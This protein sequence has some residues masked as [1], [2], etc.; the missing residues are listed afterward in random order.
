MAVNK[1]P[2]FTATPIL[3]CGRATYTEFNAGTFN[4][5]DAATY[6]KTIFT[7]SSTEGTLIE[8][9]TIS[10]MVS[11]NGAVS[12]ITNKILYLLVKDYNEDRTSILKTKEWQSFDMASE[13]NEIP[14]WEIIFQG[15]LLLEN[16]DSILINQ[17]RSNGEYPDAGGDGITWVVEGSTY[18]AQ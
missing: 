5:T 18:T 14:Y 13:F 8:R 10:P 12:T 1:Q 17:I 6:S 15:G 16:N 9:I 3:T 4:P 2:I 11:P 7:A